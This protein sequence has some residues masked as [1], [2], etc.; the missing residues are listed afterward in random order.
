MNK[1]I[2]VPSY[3]DPTNKVW[4]IGMCPD[5]EEVEQNELFVGKAGQFLLSLLSKLGKKKE[6][7]YID[8]LVDHFVLPGMSLPK[9]SIENGVSRITKLLAEYQPDVVLLV[10]SDVA[11]NI[12]KMNDDIY[13][14]RGFPFHR[15]YGGKKITFIPTFHPNYIFK[16]RDVVDAHIRYLFND[17]KFF[18]GL[19]ENPILDQTVS[20]DTFIICDN[21]ENVLFYLDSLLKSDFFAFDIETTSLSPYKGNII[22]IAF[23]NKHVCFVFDFT[24]FNSETI[25]N[26]LHEVFTNR[27]ILKIAHNLQFEAEW[28]L[29]KLGF[30]IEPP[31][32]DTMLLAFSLRPHRYGL[33]DQANFWLKVDDWAIDMSNDLLKFDRYKL[34]I[35]NAYD[36]VY[37]YKLYLFL[38]DKFEKAFAKSAWSYTY[39][40]YWREMPLLLAKA[41]YDGAFIDIKVLDEFE[42]KFKRELLQLVSRIYSY[43]PIKKRTFP[44]S[45][46]VKSCLE[47][48]PGDSFEEKLVNCLCSEQGSDLNKLYKKLSTKMFNLQSTTQIAEILIKD[49]N[50]TLPKT[51]KGNYSVS[52]DVLSKLD[53]PLANDILALRNIMKNLK[54]Y[55]VN[56]RNL[57]DENCKIHTHYNPLG[58]VTGRFSSSNPN[59]QNWPKRKNKEMRKMFAAPP[60][61]ILVRGDAKS[62][63]VM[64]L[65][66]YAKD[67]VLGNY[68][69]GGGDMHYDASLMLYKK[70]DLAKEKRSKA[71]NKLVFP[72][73]Y[74]AGEKTVIS[75]FPELSEKHVRKVYYELKNKFKAVIE[76]QQKVWNFYRKYGYIEAIHGYRRFMPMNYNRVINSP[77]QG[78][79]AFL[80]YSAWFDLIRKGYWCPLYVH[81]EIVM[82]VKDTK[83]SIKQAVKDL[84]ES[85]CCK[86]FKV[87]KEVPLEVEIKIGYNWA[88]MQDIDHN[89]Y[90]GG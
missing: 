48:V 11:T 2:V 13:S 47:L 3:G 33:K 1:K 59:L 82:V 67:P 8:N 80:V 53:V 65:Q 43:E 41:Q 45:E 42:Q 4:I 57:I 6:N 35:Y 74:G 64:V 19:I 68:L 22:S 71:K 73:F 39:E 18:V 36:A 83:E 28:F 12:L 44:L 21:E 31:V 77:I 25:I 90:L 55:V 85:I 66:M 15:V 50:I 63:E 24:K 58:T 29:T 56:I 78:F 9:D 40:K 61:Y 76:W 16:L 72:V 49:Y 5:A 17:L 86:P 46:K 84:Y 54:T 70:E 38:R 23:A 89:K 60:G 32:D 30:L 7:F 79:A 27:N 88:D 81:D 52:V 10:G 37:T 69:R 62:L 87:C 26:K 14:Y 51:D 20:S 34:L 75:A